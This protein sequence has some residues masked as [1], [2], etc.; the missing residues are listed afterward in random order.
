MPKY[1]IYL[2]KKAEKNLNQ[3]P[4]R[5]A[6]TIFAAISELENN[7]RPVGYKKLKG[8]DGYRIRCG[9]Y[10][11]IYEIF[12]STL[13]IDVINLGHRKNIYKL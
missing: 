5:T 8:R 9:N 10:R 7:P 6:E 13:V 11:I 1:T 12:E 4:E 2:S 3:L